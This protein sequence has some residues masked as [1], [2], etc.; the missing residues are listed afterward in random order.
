M[1]YCLKH[2]MMKIG[3]GYTKTIQCEGDRYA[4]QNRIV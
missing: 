2:I 1:I 4:Y 3:L